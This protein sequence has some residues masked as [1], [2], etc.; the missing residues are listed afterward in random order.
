[1]LNETGEGKVFEEWVGEASVFG[2]EILRRPV[3]KALLSKTWLE[4]CMLTGLSVRYRSAG[5]SKW[6]FR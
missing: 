6:K 1:V 4:H 5:K 3:E 2:F